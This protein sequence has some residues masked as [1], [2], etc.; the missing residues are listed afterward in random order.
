MERRALLAAFAS[1]GVFWGCWAAVLPA[2]QRAAHV[3]DGRLGLA[4]GALALSAVPVMPVAGR[5]ADRLGPRRTVPAG[6]TMFALVLALPGLAHSLPALLGCLVGLGI[7]TGALD[8]TI[9]TAA[10]GWERAEGDRLMSTAHGAFSVGVLAGSAAAGFARQL[11]AAPLAILLPVAVLVLVVAATQPAYRSRPTG[12]VT[13]TGRRLPLALLAFGVLTAGA[14]LVEDGVISWSALHLER[15][16]GAAPAVSG[17]GPGLFAG[18]MAVG[19][20]SGDRISRRL[21][22]AVVLAGA[23]GLASVGVIVLVLAPDPVVALGG[24]V[25]AGAGTSVLAPVL[26]S[27]VGAR[28]AEGRQGADLATATAIGY[29]GFVTGPPL[30]GFVSAATSLPVALAGLAGV[31]LLLAVTGPLLLRGRSGRMPA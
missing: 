6:L 19:R 1:F 12:A 9:N 27:A 18:A 2:V 15:G 7:T 21:S 10:A 8:V 13:R 5:L 20:L 25:V 17:L 16:L 3:S 14:F 28:A 22:D 23:A 26:Y 31:G 30:V 4:L 11:G 24:L 29:V